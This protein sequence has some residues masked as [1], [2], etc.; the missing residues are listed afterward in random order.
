MPIRR[1][2]FVGGGVGAA[3]GWEGGVKGAG[4]KPGATWAF[5]ANIAVM[6]IARVERRDFIEG[7]RLGA[8]ERNFWG[9]SARNRGEI[10]GVAN[11]RY[12]SD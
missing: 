2:R 7:L 11:V 4:L 5:E 12:R 1:A 3:F 10:Q 6:K 9:K 8:L